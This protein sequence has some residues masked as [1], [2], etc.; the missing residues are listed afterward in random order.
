MRICDFS[1]VGKKL[2]VA[3]LLSMQPS[4]IAQKNK[5]G[6]AASPSTPSSPS[7]SAGATASSAPIEVEWLALGAL[8][9]ILSGVADYACGAD[10]HKSLTT[11][12]IVVVLDTPAA[13]ALETYD[14][15]Y[16]QA[17]AIRSAFVDMAPKAGAGGGVDDFADT[18]G[19]VT[20][21][22]VSS[23][24]ETSSSFTIQD[25]TTAVL[26]LSQLHGDTR[27]AECKTAYYAGVYEVDEANV[28]DTATKVYTADAEGN[29]A[30]AKID[31]TQKLPTV[32]GELELLAQAR[33]ATLMA[34]L[35]RP[36]ATNNP[37]VCKATATAVPNSNP[38]VTA[39]SSTDPCFTAFN[40]LDTTYESFLTSLSAANATTGQ[41][42]ESAAREGYKMRALFEAAKTSGKPVIGIYVNVVAAGGTEQDRKNILTALFTGDWIRYSGG[43]GVNV[44]IFKIAKTGSGVLFSGVPRFRTQLTTIK[45]PAKSQRDGLDAGSNLEQVFAAQKK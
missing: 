29:I 45:A 14:T 34:V 42:M 1:S 2:I 25:P 8:D 7:T 10:K 22:A 6:A 30:D 3:V 40:N 37:K 21:V 32:S 13:Q 17:E 11:D 38:V 41:S 15:F 35:G 44:M 19:A 31:A 9:K 27:P 12:A 26:L 20:A 5:G 36:G 23:T 43:V 28:P 24:S 18:T 33:T 16:D 4:L 39:V